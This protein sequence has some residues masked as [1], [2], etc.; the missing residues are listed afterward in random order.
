MM[1]TCLTAMA[2]CSDAELLEDGSIVGE[3]TEVAL[4][5][6]AK[7]KGHPKPEL[8]AKAPRIG[9]APLTATER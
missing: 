9:E 5:S 3:P 1:W 6:F 2:L 4:V 7:E 8:K